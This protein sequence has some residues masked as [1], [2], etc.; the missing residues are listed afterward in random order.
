MFSHK[1]VCFQALDLRQGDIHC[2]IAR[3]Q[4]YLQLGDSEKALQDADEVLK[5]NKKSIKVG[6][7]DC[8]MLSNKGHKLYQAS[9]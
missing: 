5:E 4:C 3:S 1:L 6:V 2:L 9:L 8:F 7:T